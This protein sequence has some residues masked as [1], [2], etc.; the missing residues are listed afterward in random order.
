MR[1]RRRVLLVS[2][3]VMVGLLT[4]CGVRYW[5]VNGE[6]ANHFG[7]SEC[8]LPLPPG[9]VVGPPNA[10]NNDE[11]DLF[12]PMLPEQL[13][14]FYAATAD[15]AGW[16]WSQ[17]PNDPAWYLLEVKGHLFSVGF[18]PDVRSVRPQVS[19][20]VLIKPGQPYFTPPTLTP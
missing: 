10:M 7:C 12:V 6:T 2:L 15:T 16:S 1:N 8:L 18:F 5:R 20:F 4:G 17:Y 11:L 19:T 9:S 3:V 13:V 14:D